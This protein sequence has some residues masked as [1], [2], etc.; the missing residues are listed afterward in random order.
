M[1]TLYSHSSTK[2]R[3]IRLLNLHPWWWSLT[4]LS[5]RLEEVPIDNVPRY[6]A[7]S[8]TWGSKD[9][10][11]YMYCGDG[12]VPITMN[13][14]IALR[15]LRHWFRSRK[16]W[17]DAICID[18][19]SDLDKTLQIRMMSEIYSKAE[20]VV[21][22]MGEGNRATDDAIMTL[23][24][25]D[26]PDST[27]RKKAKSISSRLFSKGSIFWIRIYSLMMLSPWR[28]WWQAYFG[29]PPGSEFPTNLSTAAS[30]VV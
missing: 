12:C 11:R 9:P 1:P 2:E 16:I 29:F 20:Q 14:E 10:P 18:Q 8:Y 27:L 3:H 17:V 28:F 6:E 19:T 5:G 26:Q 15:S 23:N 24:L 7:L 22:W 30:D 4:G 13:C 21:I 25:L